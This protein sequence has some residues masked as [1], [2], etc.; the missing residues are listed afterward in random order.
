M[1]MTIR[2]FIQIFALLLAGCASGDGNY[3]SLAKRPIESARNGGAPAAPAAPAAEDPALTQEI[4]ALVERA[5]KAAAAFDAQLPDVRQKVGAAAGSAASSEAWVVAELAISSLD[6]ERYDSVYAL[7]N[8]DTLYINRANAIAAGESE[9]GTEAIAVARGDV[10]A[11]VDR[12]NDLLDELG[13]QLS[14]P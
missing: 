11:I 13:R 3:P 12:Q 1:S 8:L 7:A 5:R 10:L 6:S 4:A 14:Q 9:G 2:P